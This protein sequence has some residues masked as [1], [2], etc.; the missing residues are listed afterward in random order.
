M[1]FILYLCFLEPFE[2]GSLDSNQDEDDK[3]ISI[4]TW[5]K[6]GR[7]SKIPLVYMSQDELRQRGKRVKRKSRTLILIFTP[8]ILV[9]NILLLIIFLFTEDD[10]DFYYYLT[11]AGWR[12]AYEK[13]FLVYQSSGYGSI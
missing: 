5:K 13:N 4:P 7:T 9:L 3:I 2:L 8:I 6:Q 1:S 12:Q 10:K 11:A